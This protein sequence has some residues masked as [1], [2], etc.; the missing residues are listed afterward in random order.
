MRLEL[1]S[2]YAIERLKTNKPFI[3]E[4]ELKQF[5]E[6]AEKGSSSAA[7]AETRKAFPPGSAVLA[8]EG[9]GAASCAYAKA[10]RTCLPAR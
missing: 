8:L 10:D 1:Q 2:L 4:S 6:G 3:I 5:D 7:R 9:I